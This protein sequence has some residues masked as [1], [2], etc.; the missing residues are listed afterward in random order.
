M[1]FSRR[2][3]CAR[4]A[5]LSWRPVAL[6]DETDIH[7]GIHLPVSDAIFFLIF[8][9]SKLVCRYQLANAILHEC[10]CCSWDP[11]P[12]HK[13][14]PPPQKIDAKG[15]QGC[16]RSIQIVCCTEHTYP[17]SPSAVPFQIP[18]IRVRSD[19]PNAFS[20]GLS[21]VAVGT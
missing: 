10:Q 11:P 6:T 18:P 21:L 13:I 19:P 12:Q 15:G 8:E 1:T 4:I 20:M 3:D 5:H 9:L 17:M 7:F 14:R 16:M 2:R